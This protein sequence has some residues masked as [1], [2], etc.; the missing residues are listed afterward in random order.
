M[1]DSQ[2]V[3]QYGLPAQNKLS[4]F[5]DSLLGDVRTKDTGDAGEALT[6]LL[7]KVKELD[8]DGPERR[9]AGW[10]ASR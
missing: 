2:M 6:E 7:V 10:R 5:A 4:T 1:T 9:L 3:I 8:V